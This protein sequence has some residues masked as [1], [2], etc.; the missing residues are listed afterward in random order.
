MTGAGVGTATITATYNG[1]AYYATVRVFVDT[2]FKAWYKLDET[3][4]TTAEDSSGFGN[5]GTINGGAAWT[6]GQTGNAVDLDGT[7]DYV[8]FP[9]GVVSGAETITVAA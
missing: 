2:D 9:S 8:A 3:S 1:Q 5:N 4:R 7:N 6:A